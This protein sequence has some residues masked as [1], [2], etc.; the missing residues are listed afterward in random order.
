MK[1]DYSKLETGMCAQKPPLAAAKTKA[2]LAKSGK[3]GGSL[4]NT[5]Q[6]GPSKHANLKG[7]TAASSA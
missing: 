3:T 6:K 2:A 4:G 5:W 7:G 1:H